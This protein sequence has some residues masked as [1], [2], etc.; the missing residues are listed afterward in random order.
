MRLSFKTKLIAGALSA[1]IIGLLLLTSVA[2]INFTNVIEYELSESM[3]IRTNEATNHIITWLTSRLAEVQETVNSPIVR[4]VVE[5]NPGLDFDLQD[6][7]IDL[8]DEL[9]LSRWNFINS[10]YPDQYLSLIH[11]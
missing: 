5:L 9:N 6:E 3:S 2:Y 10:V 8:I 7:S 1:V 11:I 4:D